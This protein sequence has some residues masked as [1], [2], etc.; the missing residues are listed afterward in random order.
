MRSSKMERKNLEA[1]R[2]R[3]EDLSPFGEELSEEQ[4]RLVVGGYWMMTWDDQAGQCCI[5][6][7]GCG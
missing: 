1:R 7:D 4:L 3:I 5:D 6:H 2:T